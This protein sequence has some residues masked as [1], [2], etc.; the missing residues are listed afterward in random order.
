MTLNGGA[1][2]PSQSCTA[3]A[4]ATWSGDSRTNATLKTT[5][6][7]SISSMLAVKA[8]TARRVA[9]TVPNAGSMSMVVPVGSEK[10]IESQESDI[11]STTA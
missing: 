10:L 3:R 5:E 2:E 1:V 11:E 9:R 4:F 7:A 8:G 6:E